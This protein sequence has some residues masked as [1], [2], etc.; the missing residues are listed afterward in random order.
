[1]SGKI[2]SVPPTESPRILEPADTLD[3]KAGRVRALT[4]ENLGNSEGHYKLTVGSDTIDDT[5]EEG[6]V[7]RIDVEFNKAK[8]INKGPTRL[9]T[10]WD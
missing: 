8:L 4:I 1:M 10:S 5:I 9:R 6:G 7:D 3:V 2:Y